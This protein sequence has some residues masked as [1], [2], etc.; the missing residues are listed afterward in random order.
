ML[1]LLNEFFEPQAI[2]ETARAPLELALTK[3][4]SKARNE[5]GALA[6]TQF[7]RLGKQVWPAVDATPARTT[8]GPEVMQ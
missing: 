5:R 2:F 3:P 8:L 7:I 1:I 4:G 6:I